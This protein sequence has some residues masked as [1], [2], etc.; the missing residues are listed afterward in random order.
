MKHGDFTGLAENYRKYRPGYSHE[1]AKIISRENQNIDDFKAVDVGAGTGIWTNI[2]KDHG[3]TVITAIEPN[4]DMKSQGEIAFPD[5]NWI[6]APAEETTLENNSVNLV[7]MASSFH[8]PDFNLATKE[9]HRVLKPGGLFVAL[10][11]PRLIAVNPLL[12]EIENKLKEIVPELK[13]VSSGRSSFTQDLTEKL[14]ATKLFKDVVYLESTHVE[15]QSKERYIGLWESVNDIR[16]QAGEDRFNKFISWIHER[17]ADLDFI[18]ATY[19]TRAWVARR[20]D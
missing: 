16:V 6:Q 18:E 7:T 19:S 11:N 9:F 12:V 4:S 17:I 8:W 15:K 5:I 14:S 20:N 10:W 3:V 1:I 2:L 13:R